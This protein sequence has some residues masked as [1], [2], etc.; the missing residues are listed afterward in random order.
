MVT[1]SQLRSKSALTFIGLW[2]AATAIAI[3]IGTQT[4]P[5]SLVITPLAL[6][7]LQWL[8][9][10]VQ[11]RPSWGWFPLTLV[12]SV[13]SFALGFYVYMGLMI[14]R[15]PFGLPPQVDDLL[16]VA[17]GTAIGGAGLGLFQWIG[18]RRHSRQAHWW[19][20]ISAIAL[21]I[22]AAW[23]VPM[24]VQSVVSPTVVSRWE[25]LRVGLLSGLIGGAIKG[26]G[27]W[28]LLQS[29]R[30]HAADSADPSEAVD[31]DPVDPRD[32]STPE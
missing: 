12:G 21:A 9:L 31:P 1:L 16:S 10:R 19:I 6:G 3:A 23:V 2:I 29:P 5:F 28:V 30:L 18:L 27:M 4:G 13:I 8:V 24:G 7:L 11:A 26:I 15:L 17:I 22:G 14:Q 32:R 25:W 20:G